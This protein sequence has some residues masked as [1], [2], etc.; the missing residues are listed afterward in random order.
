MS[1]ASL[2]AVPERLRRLIPGLWFGVLLAIAFIAAPS[3]FSLLDRPS[4]GRVAGRLFALEAQLS[5][6]LCVLL[7]LL[8]RLRAGRRAAAGQ[9][10]PVSAELLLVMGVLFCTVLGHYALQ[11]MMEAARAGEGRWSFGAL[12]GVS[13]VFYGVKSLLVA[14]LAWRAARG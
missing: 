10:S 13:T 2:A 7:G 11:P 9:G 5:L 1:G 8:E 6:A 12:H 3:L 14:T 4:A